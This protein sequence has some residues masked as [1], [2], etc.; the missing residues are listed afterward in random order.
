MRFTNCL[1]RLLFL[2]LAAAVTSA[3]VSYGARPILEPDLLVR[4]KDEKIND[5]RTP[6]EAI[7]HLGEIICFIELADATFTPGTPV[8]AGA[9][10]ACNVGARLGIIGDSRKI[11]VNKAFSDAWGSMALVLHDKAGKELSRVTA[12]GIMGHPLNAVFWLI[13][14]LKRTGEK[15]NAGDIISLG[16]PSPQVTPK[17]GESYMLRYEGLPGGVLQATVSFR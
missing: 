3:L 1:S 8:D 13:Q 5:I 4:V 7:E 17:A 10:T 11:E 16:S 12:D 14:D 15:L 2:A 9:I 6:E